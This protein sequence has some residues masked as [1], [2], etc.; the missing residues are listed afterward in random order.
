MPVI[1]VYSYL[2]L[3]ILPSSC[4]TS[5]LQGAWYPRVNKE[6]S[7]FWKPSPFLQA[8]ALLINKGSS[9]PS[10]NKAAFLI[11]PFAQQATAKTKGCFDIPVNPGLTFLLH[12]TDVA[13]L[14]PIFYCLTQVSLAARHNPWQIR[15]ACTN[16][17]GPQTRPGNHVIVPPALQAPCSSVC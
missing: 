16:W 13:L 6:Q 7:A 1:Q 3:D 9:R 5:Y 17:R 15:A 12:I 2:T 11:Q 4:H 14:L 8:G 10:T